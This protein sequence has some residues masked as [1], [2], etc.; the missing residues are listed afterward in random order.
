VT[1]ATR[2]DAVAADMEGRALA[3]VHEAL[4]ARDATAARRAVEAWARIVDVA[5]VGSPAAISRGTP[6]APNLRIFL[7]ELAPD[8]VAIYLAASDALAAAGVPELDPAAER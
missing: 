6:G 4:A 5:P 2:L 1:R 7:P 8:E 3:T